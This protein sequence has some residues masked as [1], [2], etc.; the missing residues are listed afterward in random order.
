MHV[1]N[2]ANMVITALPL[3]PSKSNWGNN[4]YYKPK[5]TCVFQWEKGGNPH[6]HHPHNHARHL[7]NIKY[8]QEVDIN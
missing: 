3:S 4:P 6:T 1:K 7:K 2:G 5:Y 8:N